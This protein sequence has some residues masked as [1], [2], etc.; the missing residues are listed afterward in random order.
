MIM[1]ATVTERL[2]QFDEGLIGFYDCKN[3]IL[4]EREDIAPFLWLQSTERHDV[5]FLVIDPALVVHDYK[6]IIP[7]REWESLGV[8]NSSDGQILVTCSVGPR[9]AS[10]TG[11]LQAPLLLNYNTNSGKQ[12]I[13]TETGLAS[14]HP[15]L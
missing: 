9:T 8:S 7:N 13:L 12:I 4:V 14:R 11:N 10:S 6:T 5:G 15:L 1:K 2:I 3:F